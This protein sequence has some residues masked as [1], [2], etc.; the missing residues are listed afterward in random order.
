MANVIRIVLVLIRIAVP[1]AALWLREVV[2]L[3]FSLVAICPGQGVAG[4]DMAAICA[5][6]RLNWG[7]L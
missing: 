1:L 6:K 5:E 4:L 3:G 2:T 7:R